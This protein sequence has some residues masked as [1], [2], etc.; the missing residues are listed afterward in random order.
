MPSYVIG[1]DGGT[2]KTIAFVADL[3]GQIL[4][5]ARGPGSNATGENVDEPMGV[6]AQTTREALQKTGLRPAEVALGMFTLAGA[7][8]PEDIQRRQHFLETAGLARKVV[9]KNDTFGGLRAGTRCPYGVVIAAGTGANTAV[10]TPSGQEWVYGYYQNYGGAFDFSREAIEAVLR[11][12][13]GRGHPTR[14]TELVLGQLG[15]STVEEMLKALIAQKVEL[16]NKLALCPRVFEASFAGDEVAS[17]II[18]R[19]GLALAEYAVAAI[20]RFQMVDETF[21]V[22]LVGSVFKGPG[23]LLQDTITLAI[24][25]VAPRA[26]VVRSHFEPVVGALLLAYDALGLPVSEAMYDRLSVTCP[27]K[28]FFNTGQGI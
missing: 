7:D 24:H 18:V 26:R 12:E 28:E 3:N 11:T 14:L 2:T 9:V 8:W 17:E 15:F 23:P 27:P 16:A 21:D 4:G 5:A 6:V 22:V 13:A 10:I 25:R 20:H 1:V 19:H